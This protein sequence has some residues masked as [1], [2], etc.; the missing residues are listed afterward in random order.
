MDG[1]KEGSGLYTGPERRRRRVY[2][3]KHHEY[4]CKDG[5]CVAVRDVT[6]GDLVAD[7]SAIGRKVS[8]SVVLHKGGL[9]AA[10]K[11]NDPEIGQRIH[12]ALDADDSSDVLTS[13]LETVERPPMEILAIYER[14][15]SAVPPPK[16]PA[17][18]GRG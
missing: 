18:R 3:T 2:V 10:S 7:H 9:L 5:V 17:P 11:S 4:H 14:E 13:T 16:D 1:K 12:F 6:T 15:D 8:G